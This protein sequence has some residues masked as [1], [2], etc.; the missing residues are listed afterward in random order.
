MDTLI[1]MGIKKKLRIGG[2][3]MLEFWMD[4]GNKKNLQKIRN[5]F[6]KK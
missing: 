6:G 5:I 4:I 1:N 2:Y 3:P